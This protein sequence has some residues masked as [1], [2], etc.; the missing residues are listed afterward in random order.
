MRKLLSL[1]LTAWAQHPDLNFPTFALVSK[2]KDILN[3]EKMIVRGG[4]M[5]AGGL[6]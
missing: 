3:S 6:S 1:E 4:G 5:G 2:F